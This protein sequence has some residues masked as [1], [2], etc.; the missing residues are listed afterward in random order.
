IQEKYATIFSELRT[1]ETD[2][3][4]HI[5][6]VI[7]YMTSIFIGT[8]LW[9]ITSETDMTPYHLAQLVIKLVGNGHVTVLGIELEK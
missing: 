8:L 7:E 5:D 1:T 4:V 2:T 6:F 3:D 9:W